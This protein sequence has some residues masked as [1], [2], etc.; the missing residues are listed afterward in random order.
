MKEKIVERAGMGVVIFFV[1]ISVEQFWGLGIGIGTGI[2]G[3]GI[4]MRHWVGHVIDLYG[5]TNLY[6]F[7]GCL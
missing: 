1:A 4:L 3:M 5:G 2:K 6:P 7:L